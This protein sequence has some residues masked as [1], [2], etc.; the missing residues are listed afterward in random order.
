[1][2]STSQLLLRCHHEVNEGPSKMPNIPRL[3][4]SAVRHPSCSK[5]FIEPPRVCILPVQTCILCAA[6]SVAYI[7]CAAHNTLIV[8]LGPFI[9]RSESFWDYE[10]F[11]QYLT[12]QGGKRA[13]LMVGP[14]QGM[15]TITHHISFQAFGNI[16]EPPKFLFDFHPKNVSKGHIY[17]P[18]F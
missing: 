1:M 2:T 10:N 3:K 12:F 6:E 5:M 18:K 13:P 15:T 11:C 17:L 14:Y 16:F 4:G 8:Y 7:S 9:S